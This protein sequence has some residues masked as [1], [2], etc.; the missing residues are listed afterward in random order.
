MHAHPQTILPR[1]PSPRAVLDTPVARTTA[2]PAVAAHA[3]AWATP[4]QLS[5]Q[6]HDE[7]RERLHEQAATFNADARRGIALWL[8]HMMALGICSSAD[9]AAAMSH[10]HPCSA[11]NR[12]YT[13]TCTILAAHLNRIVE[14]HSRGFGDSYRSAIEIALGLSADDVEPVI[15]LGMSGYIEITV[16][17]LHQVQAPLAA[18]VYE[19]LELVSRCFVAFLSPSDTWDGQAL[20]W[21]DM[22]AE[23]YERL[24]DM[25]DQRGI[26][27]V[28]AH[29]QFSDYSHFYGNK[30]EICEQLEHGRQM[31]EAKPT[32]LTVAATKTPVSQARSLHQRIAQFRLV[33]GGHPWCEFVEHVC[34]TIATRFRDD[35]AWRVSA[36]EDRDALL[37]RHETDVPMFFGLWVTSGS[38]CERSNAEEL[39]ENMGQAGEEAVDCYSLVQLAST[40]LRR[41]LHDTAIGIGLLLRAGA[42]NLQ[43][44]ESTA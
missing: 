37:E 15:L 29:V 10:C 39:H 11:L 34:A 12:L 17:S 41:K 4:P 28:V 43:T 7:M 3:L 38:E 14:Q 20:G 42:V 19:S 26:D 8:R 30:T 40:Q 18:M 5:Q 25:R 27:E 35:R 22:F 6:C 21:N 31:F 23:E 16:D 32:W 9:V 33:H 2:T 36:R 24:R 44:R 1:S 13:S